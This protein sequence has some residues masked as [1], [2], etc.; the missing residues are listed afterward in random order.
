MTPTR[1]LQHCVNCRINMIRLYVIYI[2]QCN[3]WTL[4][5][6]AEILCRVC[7]PISDGVSVVIMWVS[8]HVVLAGNSPADI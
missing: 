7:G 8:S 5:L 4:P 1:R 6:I 2:T 3:A